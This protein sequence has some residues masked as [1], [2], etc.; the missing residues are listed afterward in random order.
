MNEKAWSSNFSLTKALE[1]N[2]G[3]EAMD[4]RDFLLTFQSIIWGVLASLRIHSTA[5]HYDDCY[6]LGLIK[7]FAAYEDFP[8]DFESEE[9][10]YQFGGY[11][12]QKIKWAVIDEC[13]KIKRSADRETDLP[14]RFEELNIF[15]T[16]GIEAGCLARLEMA[17][18]IQSLTDQE[19]RYLALYLEYENMT[20]VAQAMGRS[21][22]TVYQI[23]KRI[24][25][26]YLAYD[27][28]M[29]DTNREVSK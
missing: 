21:R 15:Q 24:A 11:A 7:L 6:Q 8:G 20:Q 14:M 13:R 3:C 2:K 26:K 28:V 10:L 5:S 18:F 19:R 29:S 22:K 23:R 4:E 12:Y 16:D 25:G 27:Q 1:F 17:D 9:G